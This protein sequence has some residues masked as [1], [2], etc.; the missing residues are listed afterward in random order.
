[1]VDW[2][3]RVDHA[4]ADL[5][6][7]VFITLV[8]A[9]P[10]IYFEE[11]IDVVAVKLDLIRDSIVLRHSSQ[12]VFILFT[13]DE[14]AVINL[15][16]R[17]TS[18]RDSS[19]RLHCHRWT[20]QANAS[21]VAFP[22]LVDVELRG[23]PAHAWEGSVAENL[24]NPYGWIE[25]IHH[26]TLIREDYS[27]FKCSAWCFNA[28]EVPP[29]RDLVIVE[30]LVIAVAEALPVKHALVYLIDITV[31]PTVLESQDD[32]SW[33]SMDESSANPSRRQCQ[34]ARSPARGASGAT[35]QVGTA[36]PSAPT[37]RH[38]AAANTVG[39]SSSCSGMA[40]LPTVD[41]SSAVPHGTKPEESAACGEFTAVALETDPLVPRLAYLN[42]STE[43]TFDDHPSVASPTL[44]CFDLI[45]TSAPLLAA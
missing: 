20:R 28:K 37:V 38:E 42:T 4:E 35:I 19:I 14:E 26:S 18:A 1:M 43:A 11:A 39:D 30:P 21:S 13:E 8:E 25:R 3:E 29:S 27:V 9:S 23:V 31:A 22:T 24:L 34:R 41:E 5:H 6:K 2:L 16:N 12:G 10:M 40:H 44:M 15:A 45:A 36:F 17:D 7:A 33:T 32:V